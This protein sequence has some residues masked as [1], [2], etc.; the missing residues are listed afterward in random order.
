M[1]VNGIRGALC[2]ALT[3]VFPPVAYAQAPNVAKSC[4]DFAAPENVAPG[5]Q[6]DDDPEIIGAATMQ[7]DGTIVLQLRARTGPAIGDGLLR[8]PV[9]HQQYLYVCRH[10]GGI[11]IGEQKHVRVFPSGTTK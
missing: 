1:T 9:S 4:F 2:V 3:G 8:Y 6:S 7:S 10:L 11:R 5:G